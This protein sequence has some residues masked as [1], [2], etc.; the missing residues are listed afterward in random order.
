[1]SLLQSKWSNAG[2]GTF[3]KEVPSGIVN[4]SNVNFITS[5]VPKSGSLIVYIDKILELNYTYTNANKTIAFSS[6]PT[7]GQDVYVT[8]SY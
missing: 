6:A 3:L 5:Q 2:G 7:L 1:M 8:Y 4:G